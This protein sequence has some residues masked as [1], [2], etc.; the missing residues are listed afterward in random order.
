MPRKCFKSAAVAFVNEIVPLLTGYLNY[1]TMNLYKKKYCSF[2]EGVAGRIYAVVHWVWVIIRINETLQRRA[3]LFHNSTSEWNGKTISICVNLT[4]RRHSESAR[5]LNYMSNIN[6]LG[7]VGMG[8]CFSSFLRPLV[9][10]KR[11]EWRMKRINSIH[12]YWFNVQM[13]M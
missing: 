3:G 11:V 2:V 7:M 12:L 10:G 9:C 5:R 1:H 13:S 4:N 6:V 8:N